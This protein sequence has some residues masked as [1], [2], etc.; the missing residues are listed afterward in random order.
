MSNV[1]LKFQL[2]NKILNFLN[3]Q[4][5]INPRAPTEGAYLYMGMDL[6]DWI[7]QDAIQF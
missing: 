2:L 1:P 7:Y 3:P 5:M 6:R 4:F